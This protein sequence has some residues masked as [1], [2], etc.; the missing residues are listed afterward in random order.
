MQ[1]DKTVL[2]CPGVALS[3]SPDALREL[4]SAPPEHLRLILGYSGWGP[5]QL[6]AEMAHG[7]WL[8]ADVDAQLIFATPAEEMWEKALRSLGIDPETIVQGF[9]IH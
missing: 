1:S 6:A 3:S 5:G 9:G 2:I 8:H 4:A 7:S